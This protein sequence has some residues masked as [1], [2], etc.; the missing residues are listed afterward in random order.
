[1]STQNDADVK[2]G[3]SD[4]YLRDINSE[5]DY[6][7]DKVKRIH[8]IYNQN[9]GKSMNEVED[10]I[11]SEQDLAEFSDTHGGVFTVLTRTTNPT[12]F[13]K[14]YKLLN[15]QLKVKRGEATHDEAMELIDSMD[16]EI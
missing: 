3:E 2:V 13:T 5:H 16:I 11:L 9:I 1:M 10:I 4:A 7:M 14:M 15:L 8:L 6:V 12:R